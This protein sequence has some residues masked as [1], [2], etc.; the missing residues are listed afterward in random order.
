[1]ISLIKG[2]S[3]ACAL[4]LS[5]FLVH[6]TAGQ[7]VGEECF[8]RFKKGRPDFVLDADDSVKA[9]ATVISSPKLYNYRDCVQACCKD[10]R[11][12]VAFVER[13]TE[14]DASISSCFLFDCLYKQKYVCRF[15]SRK[16]Y[17]SYIMDKVYE[18]YHVEDINPGKAKTRNRCFFF[19]LKVI[20]MLLVT[21]LFMW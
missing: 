19:S 5:L 20:S 21:P 10:S 14:E 1:M 13:G 17:D 8:S 12:N 2:Q 16:G 3:G 15:V 4:L 6:S 7:L 9:G 11:C 18:S